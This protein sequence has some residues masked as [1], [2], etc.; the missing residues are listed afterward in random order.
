MVF[1]IFLLLFLVFF[2]SR[3]GKKIGVKIKKMSFEGDPSSTFYSREIFSVPKVEKLKN[4]K[5]LESLKTK[6]SG[7]FY[8][9]PF[10]RILGF[11]PKNL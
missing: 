7:L 5:K 1:F 9:N 10:V 11:E 6:L 4:Q 3:K 2:L 8:L